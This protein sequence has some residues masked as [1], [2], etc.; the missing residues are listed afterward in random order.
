MKENLLIDPDGEEDVT[1]EKEVKLTKRGSINPLR[2]VPMASFE[3]HFAEKN[4]CRIP[5]ISTF[6][7]GRRRPEEKIKINGDAL[8]VLRPIGALILFQR[9]QWHLSIQYTID[10]YSSYRLPRTRSTS[11][12]EHVYKCN[13]SCNN[14]IFL[15]TKEHFVEKVVSRK[16]FFS[17]VKSGRRS[18]EEIIMTN[19]NALRDQMVV[20]TSLAEKIINDHLKEENLLI[21]PK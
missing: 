7:S 10:D 15:L 21:D 13:A 8:T 4:D 11:H 6:K 3:G 20:W 9:F 2:K 1:G 16:L 14:G 18:P 17:T 12:A 5:S 19:R